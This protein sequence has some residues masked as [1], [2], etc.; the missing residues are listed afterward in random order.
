MSENESKNDTKDESE[1][2]SA[3][4]KRETSNDASTQEKA[5]SKPKKKYVFNCTKCGQCCE[6]REFVPVSFEDVR[7]WT[8]TG[9]INAIFPNLKIQ[10]FKT[11]I[12]EGKQSQEFISLVLAGSEDGCSMYDKENKLCNI[13]HAL[14]LECKAFPLGYNGKNYYI[15]DKAV[16]GLGEGTMTKERLIEDRDSARLDFEARVETQL[17]LPLVYSL[18]MQNIL[19]QQQK[20]MEDMPEDKRKQLD[21]LL[22]GAGKKPT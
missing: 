1:T 18:F 5:E 13:Y 4:E 10:T 14:P 12:E 16:P 3:E 9:I 7:N 17:M 22:K 6:K 8:K 20:V 19:E 21:E 2:K 11:A 15:K